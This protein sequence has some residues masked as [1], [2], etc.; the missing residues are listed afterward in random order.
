[1]SRHDA[2]CGPTHDHSICIQLQHARPLPQTTPVALA[3][4]ATNLERK[5]TLLSLAIT[6]LPA[7]HSLPRAP[8]HI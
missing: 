2:R 8:P 3:F 7:G 6:A 1:E 5:P 4:S